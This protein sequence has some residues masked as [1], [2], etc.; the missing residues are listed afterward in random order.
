MLEIKLVTKQC[1]PICYEHA[2][3]NIGLEER[4]L[5]LALLA[6]SVITPH[7]NSLSAKFIKWSKTLKQFV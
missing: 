6:I 5:V 2:A 1:A 7:F 4:R 3:K